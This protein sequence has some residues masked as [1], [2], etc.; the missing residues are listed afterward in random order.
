MN[1]SNLTIIVT[2]LAKAINSIV[3]LVRGG[4]IFQA[5]GAFNALVALRDVDFATALA[6]LKDLGMEER[7]ALEQDFQ[8]ALQLDASLE[9]KIAGLVNALE[10]LF[11]IGQDGVSLVNQGLELIARVRSI[12]GV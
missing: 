9:T 7:R 12:L 3:S 11:L 8:G 4:G 1:T 10:D 5:I 6:E 2:N